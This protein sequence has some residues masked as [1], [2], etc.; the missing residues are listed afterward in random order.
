MEEEK[1]KKKKNKK[2]KNKPNKI[3]DNVPGGAREPDHHDQ[4][5]VGE[6][7]E[8]TAETA[9]MQDND[10]AKIDKDLDKDLSIKPPTEPTLLEGDQQYWMD[11]EAIFEEKIK[12]LEKEK[13][14]HTE[15]AASF[16][17][18][19]K[20]LESE[21]EVYAESECKVE[22]RITQLENENI[23]H[24]RKVASLEEKTLLLQKEKD[25]L[26]HRVSVL[27]AQISQLWNEKD[28]WLQKEVRLE[29]TIKQIEEERDILIEKENL[30]GE[31]VSK[32]NADNVFLQTQVKELEELQRSC[33]LEN[34][35][36]KE[37]VTTLQSQIHVHVKSANIPYSSS[38]G[39][40]VNELCINE[41]HQQG[42]PGKQDPLSSNSGPMALNVESSYYSYNNTDSS[43]IDH[44]ITSAEDSLVKPTQILPESEDTTQ[45]KDGSNDGTDINLS[46]EIESSEIVQIPLEDDDAVAATTESESISGD[47]NAEVPLS[48]APLIGAPFRLFSFVARYV[49]GADL[50]DK[51]SA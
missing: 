49:S 25:V 34:Q 4:N 14:L 11:R 16:E 19:I 17:E 26:L 7:R 8:D 32:L 15:K 23:I 48:D 39:N 22:E 10:A 9:E 47:E 40:L 41:L 29:E 31:A 51:S 43:T 45:S 50:V 46:D 20:Q 3:T 12:Q 37:T 1:K 21:K 2:K 13:E 24:I 33:V 28:S 36:L 6:S 27:E 44:E 42:G 18:K 5:H 30:M 35:L 38:A